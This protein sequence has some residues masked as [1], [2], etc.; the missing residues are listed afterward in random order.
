MDY[1]EIAQE[2]CNAPAHYKD[3]KIAGTDVRGTFDLTTRILL[4]TANYS[5]R[6]EDYVR[7]LIVLENQGRQWGVSGSRDGF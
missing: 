1:D 2:V 5:V 3:F 7:K 6:S 4:W